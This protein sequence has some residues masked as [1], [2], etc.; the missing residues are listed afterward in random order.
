MLLK[1]EPKTSEYVRLSMDDEGTPLIWGKIRGFFPD[2]Q[3]DGNGGIRV[4]FHEY[5]NLLQLLRDYC[6]ANDIIILPSPGIAERIARFETTQNKKQEFS[7]E[8]LDRCLK[9]AGFT[10][11]LKSFQRKNVI[12]MCK[13]WQGASFSVPGAGKTTEAL[14]FFFALRE[15]GDTLLVVAPKNA[16]CAWEEQLAE[17]V[18]AGNR[19]F[20]RLTGGE[21]NAK[22]LLSER[23]EFF[24]INYH[25]LASYQ[26]VICSYLAENPGA[27]VFLDE[28]HRAKNPKSRT[29]E[30]IRKIAVLPKGKLILSGTPMPQSQADLVP[31]VSFL[32]P[33]ADIREDNVVERIQPIY[34]RTTAPELGIPSIHYEYHSIPLDP[35]EMEAYKKMR[36]LSANALSN[37]NPTDAMFMRKLGKSV[38]RLLSFVAHPASLANELG[39][40][41]RRLVPYLSSRDGKKMA[42]VCRRAR[43]LAAQGKKV[44]IWS[45][46]VKNVELLASRLAD[47]G[48]D[49]IHGGVQAGSDEDEGTREQKIKRFHEDPYAKILVANPAAASEGI[50]LHK[51]CQHAIYLDRSFNAAY[52]LQSQDRI[53]RIGMPPN[54]FPTVEIVQCP[55]TIDEV[56]DVR[57]KMKID[58]MSQM[59]GDPSITV[60][61]EI[62]PDDDDDD[63]QEVETAGLSPADCAS[64]LAHLKA[65]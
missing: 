64:I 11:Q 63:A 2:Y 54:T 32:F 39:Y 35:I 48:A 6:E 57:L 62:F 37:P 21:A 31:Q 33:D 4:A 50:S 13:R 59:L 25:S 55:G 38:M 1:V 41:D 18:P 27:F 10:R 20:V 47:L 7:E 53:H 43:E 60:S 61:G 34:V 12:K 28:S 26:K 36:I 56:V 24:L 52:F 5:V 23:H 17:C 29:A 16:F 49:Y 8:E 40:I 45:S 46:F 65:I 9:I 58:A 19:S 3:P 44:M 14:A 51:V 30:A 42:Y 15:S 22:R